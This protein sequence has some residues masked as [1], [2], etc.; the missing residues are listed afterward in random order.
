M[1]PLL[2][3]YWGA[4]VEM[5]ILVLIG[6]FFI[7]LVVGYIHF[8]CKPN[9]RPS[10]IS[11]DM[12]KHKVVNNTKYSSTRN[13]ADFDP[14]FDNDKIGDSSYPNARRDAVDKD[15]DEFRQMHNAALDPFDDND[16]SKWIHPEI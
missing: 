16:R 9:S 10:S 3:S 11:Y 14:V 4:S 12:E 7:L 8:L 2:Y 5:A 15:W 1:I 6:V 13:A